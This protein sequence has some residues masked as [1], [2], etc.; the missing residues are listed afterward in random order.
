M[1][2]CAI[3]SRADIALVELRGNGVVAGR[4]GP[5]EPS[6]TWRKSPLI[7][8]LHRKILTAT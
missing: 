5:H 1:C 4:T 3:A 2:P 6:L 7:P 8:R